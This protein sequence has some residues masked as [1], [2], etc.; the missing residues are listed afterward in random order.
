VT[1]LDDMALF[2]EYARLSG[3][4]RRFDGSRYPQPIA[5]EYNRYIRRVRAMIGSALPKLTGL[6]A[7]Y[8]DFVE[9]PEFNARAFKH[10]DRYFIAIFDGIPFIVS[11][12]VMRMLADGQLFPDVGDPK[13]EEDNLPLFAAFTPNA[14]RISESKFGVVMPK[15]AQRQVYAFHLC[16]SLFDFL[17][18]HEMSHIAHGHAGYLDAECGIPYVSEA[19][20]L[21]G[22][23]S[24]NLEL[25]AMEMDADFSA[26]LPVVTT[27]KRVVSDRAQLPQPMADRYQDPA[28]AIFDMGVAVC[29]LFRLFGDNRI[30]GVDLSKSSHP[31]TRWRQMMILNAMGNYV[32]QFWD[33]SLYAP[34][35]QAFTR[36]IAQVENAFERITGL[37]QEAEGLHDVWGISGWGYASTIADCWNNTLRPK[38]KK[39]AFEPLSPYSFSVPKS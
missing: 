26:S 29:I 36:A 39:Y 21:P 27:V 23:P 1:A 7:V 32:E 9:N 11:T 31:P 34:A 25:Q 20:W 28:Q 30:T 2:D 3:I 4:G 16:N 19:S 24:G 13:E 17:A 35:E 5:D 12:L 6:P 10:T 33:S 22:T 37:P 15:N 18:A 14:A 38:L 8:A